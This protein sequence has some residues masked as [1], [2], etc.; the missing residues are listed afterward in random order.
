MSTCSITYLEGFPEA[1]LPR[2]IAKVVYYVSVTV[3]MTP[4]A[5]WM[6]PCLSPLTVIVFV[7]SELAQ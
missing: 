6:V 4:S 7:A 5:L 1:I 3:G 2:T